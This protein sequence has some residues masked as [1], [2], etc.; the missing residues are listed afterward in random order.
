L[1]AG[2][3][4]SIALEHSAL[5]GNTTGVEAS[6]VAASSTLTVVLDDNALIGNG[7]AIN[8]ALPAVVLSRGN[9]AAKLNGTD[10]TGPAL[11]SLS[12]V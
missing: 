12:G 8:Y 6:A 1:S 3:V 5:N 11:T 9:N 7:T 10:V 2:D 4:V